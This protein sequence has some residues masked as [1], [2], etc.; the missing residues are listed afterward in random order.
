MT[1]IAMPRVHVGQGTSRG[2]LT[3]FPV[4]AETVRGLRCTTGPDAPLAVEELHP[5]PRVGE[6]VVRN[7]GASPSL[8]LQGE[9]LEGG[10]QHRVAARSVLL[11]AGSAEVVEVACVEEGRWS[12]TGTH[13]R[14]GRFAPPAVR[15]AL[16]LPDRQGEVWRRV[17]AMQGRHGSSATSSLLDHAGHREAEATALVQGLRVLAGQNGV[18]VGI[19]GQPAQ[20]ELFSDTAQLLTHWSALLHA[21]AFDALGQAPEATPGRRARRFAERL[22]P[23]RVEV[24]RPAGIALEARGES[25]HHTVRGLVAADRV[26]HLSA[27]SRRHPLL[28]A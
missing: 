10:R 6:V 16:D 13:R 21:A 26:V 12:G 23:V 15:A 14:R 25:A 5:E 3:V 11:A 19:A 4:W 8:L 24:V 20:L 27:P 9:L 18:L 1:S 17:G 22:A 28:V 2:A 7:V